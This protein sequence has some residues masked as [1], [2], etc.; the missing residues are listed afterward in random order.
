MLKLTLKNLGAHK[1]R[2]LSTSLAVILGVA[3]L[4]ATLTLGDTMRAGFRVDIVEGVGDTAVTVRGS[5][6][7]GNS[8]ST[9]KQSAALPVSLVDQVALVDGVDEVAPGVEGVAQLIGANGRPIGGNGPPTVGTNWVPTGPLN[10]YEIADGRA[11]EADGEVVIDRGAAEKGKLQVGDQTIVR[12]PQPTPVTIVGIATF[13]ERDTLGGATV[14][15]FTTEQA[16]ELL[17][18]QPGK[19]STVGMTAEPDI[20]ESE[21]RD[22]VAATLPA[23]VEA[24][25]GTQL[26]EEF[27]KDIDEGFLNFFETLLLAF[28]AIA[29][30]VATFSIYNTFAILVAQRT[31]ESA[32]LRALGASR[33][34]VLRS[35]TLEALVIG[36]VASMLGLAAGYGLGSGLLQL[37]EG[38]DLELPVGIQFNA[39]T[40][41]AGLLVG[42]GVTLIASIAPAIKASRVAPLAALRDVAVDRSG[43]SI[44]RAITGVVFAAGGIGL[45]FSGAN[46][47]AMGT[48]GL[49]VLVTLI[50]AILLG[51][52]VARPASAVLGSPVA[53]LRGRAGV[54]ARRNSMRNPRRTAGTASAL[55]I[56][57]AVVAAFTVLAASIKASIGH[58]A[59]ESVLANLV[60]SQDNFSAPGLDRAMVP[61]LQQL[62]ELE[63]VVGGGDGFFQID[64]KTEQPVVIDTTHMD[65]VA[66]M[67]V[68]EG[69]LADL[70]ADGMAVEQ[71][72]AEEQGWTIGTEVPVTWADGQTTTMTVE[73]LY[74]V[75]GLFGDVIITPS[76]YTPHATQPTDLVILMRTAPGVSLEQAK[77]AV[78]EVSD[79][80]YAPDVQTRDEYL[81]DV[82]RQIDQ[83][84]AFVYGLLAIAILIAVMGIGNTISLSVH[85]RTRELGLLRAI[86]QARRQTRTMVRWESVI[87]AV[88]GTLGGIG[89]GTFAGWATVRAIGEGEGFT[90]FDIPV[91]RLAI[92]VVLGAVAGVLAARRPAKRAA[93]LDVLTAIA[94]D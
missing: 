23:G 7:L 18:G 32:L 2:L 60:I 11:P 27:Q 16:S 26:Q 40:I 53:A 73:A 14:T 64:G 84:L 35:V 4:S 6:R 85:E 58:T 67:E 72:H 91:D 75:K 34:Q 3:F 87:V 61:A 1:R 82:N 13:G 24:V 54:L 30:L 70:G 94:T 78:Q 41:V 28:A 65:E 66:D 10:H 45:M 46:G 12:T 63:T 52:V 92:V 43:A 37:L 86:G 49:G 25:T 36:F 8:D 48:V 62:P 44:W 29:L 51:P 77:A 38:I 59:K 39:D 50:G 76:A 57:V 74:G 17:L 33:R 56:G 31:R 47:N 93:K 89:F 22:R 55:M 90:T 21:L 83:S 81:A 20:T 42:V 9:I 79:R 15:F 69:S 68:A 19:V 71:D 5:T 80:F 88:F